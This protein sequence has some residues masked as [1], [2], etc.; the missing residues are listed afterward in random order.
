MIY[1]FLFPV[2]M[3]FS[4]IFFTSHGERNWPFFTFTGF[5]VFAAASIRSVCLHKKAGI[6]IVSSTSAA[7]FISSIEWMSDITGI[8]NL[9]L[10]SERILSPL[11][12]P[13]PLY[14]E[15]DVLFAL[16]N[17]LLKTK[18]RPS[19]PQISFSFSAV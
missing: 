3:N 12:I 18:G 4:I 6:W 7:G 17:E 10:T 16:S 2:D 13:G 15:T 5:P 8:L 19:L 1:I 14:E 9:V 11:S